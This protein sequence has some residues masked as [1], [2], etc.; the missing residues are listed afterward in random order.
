MMYRGQAYD[1]ASTMARIRSEVQCRIKQVNSKSM[2]IPCAN[3]SLNLA[4]VHAVASS[5]H[6]ATLFAVVE[7]VYSFFS[8]ST[9]RWE[10]LLKHVPIV[11]KRVIQTRW[12]AHYKA[13]K[14]L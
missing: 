9:Q 4:G 13:L 11:V 10:V 2:F 8:A 7:W 3:H 14:A 1:N 6:S 5:E 12:S